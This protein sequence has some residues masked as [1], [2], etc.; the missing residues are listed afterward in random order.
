[1]IGWLVPAV[2]DRI[3]LIETN[4]AYLGIPDPIE[5]GITG[6]VTKVT[7]FNAGFPAYTP[8]I[9]WIS[10][11]QVMVD[12]DNGRNLMLAI[13]PDRIEIILGAGG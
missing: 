12:W 10:S 9:P 8:G 2:A 3:R 6:T 7:L 13:P 11:Y 5:P 1:M 4:Y